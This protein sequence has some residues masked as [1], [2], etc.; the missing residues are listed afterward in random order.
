MRKVPLGMTR[1]P[2]VEAQA[3]MADWIARV[4]TVAASGRAPKSEMTQRRVW[5]GA[6]GSV[7]LGLP[8]SLG[9]ETAG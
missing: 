5:F 8:E 2:P 6:T 7:Y 1:V 9:L 3:S 4:L